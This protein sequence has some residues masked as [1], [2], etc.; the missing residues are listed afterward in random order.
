MVDEQRGVVEGLTQAWAGK[1]PTNEAF[2]AIAKD[3]SKREE[4]DSLYL[5][6]PA[7]D[8][9]SS[10]QGIV[11][12]SSFD[13]TSRGW[14]KAAA[15]H[16]G[17]QLSEIYVDAFQQ[18]N[19]ITLS[20]AL[21]ANGRLEGVFGV[22]LL[23][24]NVEKKVASFKVRETGAAFLLDEAGRFICHSDL[25]INDN[26]HAQGEEAARRFL[27]KESSFFE[28]TYMG[29]AYYYAVHPVGSTGWNLVLFVPQAEVLA[30]ISDLKLAMAGGSVVALALL[31]VLLFMMAQSIAGPIENVNRV[32]MEVAKGNLSIELQIGRAHV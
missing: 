27:A 24:S 14:Y 29:T 31:G 28:N 25:T 20:K 19:V 32:A 3:F 12:R 23:F 4:V 26:V 18:V 5:G 10:R 21:K 6:F 22:D 1:V 13:A 30:E 15:Q 17:V 16:D 2:L 8:F 9:I 7:R 11:P